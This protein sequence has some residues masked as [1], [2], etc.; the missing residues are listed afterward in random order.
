MK[1]IWKV[2]ST[3]GVCSLVEAATATLAIEKCKECL[4]VVY[5]EQFAD[6][7]V[8]IERLGMLPE[9]FIKLRFLKV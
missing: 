3:H 2:E 9:E 4:G 7:V 6:N 8:K 5:A 1:Y